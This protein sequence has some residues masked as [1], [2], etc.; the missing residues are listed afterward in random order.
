MLFGS[1]TPW[2]E[3]E[4]YKKGKERNRRRDMHPKS[5]NPGPS[6]GTLKIM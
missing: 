3:G 2:A 4:I 5:I 6:I 1:Q